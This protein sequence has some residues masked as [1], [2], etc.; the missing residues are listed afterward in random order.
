[1][2][3]N[4]GRL[5]LVAGMALGLAT[6][7]EAR[8]L[9]VP[10]PQRN[11]LVLHLPEAWQSQ[12]RGRDAS[13]PPVVAVSGGDPRS[14]QM[15]LT[16]AWTP[17]GAKAP[18]A[19]EVR[20]IAQAAADKLRARVAETDI[21][22]KDMAAPGKTGFYFAATFK[23]PEAGGFRHITQGAIGFEDL[24]ITFSIFATDATQGLVPRALEVLRTLER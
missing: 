8:D 17:R 1:M 14:F 5:A 3:A 6:S 20:H 18:T 7:L 13:Q 11:D 9:R 10:L 24:R 23:Q 15:L 4:L 2:F 12:V 19:A 21:A 16:P 22:L